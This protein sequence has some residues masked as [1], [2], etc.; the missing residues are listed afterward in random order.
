ML[1]FV[2]LVT[3]VPRSERKVETRTTYFT[4]IMGIM[5]GFD[6]VSGMVEVYQFR[7]HMEVSCYSWYT[8]ICV[9]LYL[10][11]AI[12]GVVGRAVTERRMPWKTCA[13]VC[14]GSA[15]YL[16]ITAVVYDWFRRQIRTPQEPI[17]YNTISD[18]IT[19]TARDLRDP[20][21]WAGMESY[22]DLPGCV[23]SSKKE[24][25][26]SCELRPGHRTGA[27]LCQKCDQK[28]LSA[29]KVKIKTCDIL[30]AVHKKGGATC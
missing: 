24:N 21:T 4:F 8:G 5:A 7:P 2:R 27:F 9:G 14:C 10:A 23:V 12:A 29:K 18:T 6:G 11:A 3:E 25:K 15:A 19:S 22:S 1:E 13:R 26:M 16:G 20:G 28:V 30:K 17:V